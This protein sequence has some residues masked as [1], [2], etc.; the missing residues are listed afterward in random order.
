MNVPAYLHRIGYTGP[1][2]PTLETLR[3]IHRAH[4]ET[5]PFENLD[6]AIGRPIVLD[7]NRFV[8]KVV[9]ENRGG[10]CYELNGA[11]AA[12]LRE[13][14]FHVTLL[15]ARAPRKDGS[16]GPEF[17]HLTLRVDL[18]DPWLVDVGFG[19]CFLEPLLLKQGIEQ[20]QD[21]ATFRIREGDSWLTVERQQ[22][23]SS[24][25]TE[26]LFTLAP[27]H[28]EEFA[29]MCHYHQT[30][31]ESHFTQKRLATRATST[32]RVTLSDIRLI[33]TENGSRQERVLASEAEWKETIKKTFGLALPNYCI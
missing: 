1:I 28:L 5:V 17:D 4:L 33:V 6:I 16:P 8:R 21:L 25:K 14:G 7:E 19:E 10:F 22:P 26:Y 18:A 30:S 11:L 23:D 2:A 13:M 9:E 29:D 27:R 32:G 24:W 12:L 20:K 3:R 15:S 31:P